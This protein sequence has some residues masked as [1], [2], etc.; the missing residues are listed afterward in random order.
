MWP[1][2]RL[3]TMY[4]TDRLMRVFDEI[5]N[6]SR[7]DHKEPFI[8]PL[9]SNRTIHHFTL[10]PGEPRLKVERDG[11]LA[12]PIFGI[13]F[14]KVDWKLSGRERISIQRKGLRWTIV[15]GTRM[16]ERRL[17]GIV[18]ALFS[19]N[20]ILEESRMKKMA[21]SGMGGK[22]EAQGGEGHGGRS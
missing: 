5:P 18:K 17:D 4:N 14:P 12:S 15:K 20:E 22:K 3:A 11:K 9:S 2:V 21:S 1:F 6:T 19:L 8:T 7:M 10:V 16:L 13:S